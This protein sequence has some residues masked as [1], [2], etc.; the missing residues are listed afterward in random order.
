MC[1]NAYADLI[2]SITEYILLK[3]TTK[4]VISQTA[5]PLYFIPFTV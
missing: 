4:V 1:T 3:V 2:H 5:F